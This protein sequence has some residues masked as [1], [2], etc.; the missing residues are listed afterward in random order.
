MYFAAGAAGR[1]RHVPAGTV[2]D[3]LGAPTM[4]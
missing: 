4:P 3:P 2:T 1:T